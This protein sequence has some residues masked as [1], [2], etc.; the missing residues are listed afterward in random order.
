MQKINETIRLL[1]KPQD[2][3]HRP[4]LVIIHK[5][6]VRPRLDLDCVKNLYAQTYNSYFQQK[7]ESIKSRTGAG[8]FKGKLHQELGLEAVLNRSWSRKL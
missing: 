7:V 5:S 4:P 2:V 8:S 6:F 3:L 1:R